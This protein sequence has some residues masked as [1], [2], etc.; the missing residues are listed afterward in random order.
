MKIAVKKIEKSQHTFN[1][2]SQRIHGHSFINHLF[3][4]SLNDQHSLFYSNRLA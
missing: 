1:K 3:V 4:L 2:N